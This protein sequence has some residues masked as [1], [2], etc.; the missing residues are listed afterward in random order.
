RMPMERVWAWMRS[1]DLSSRVFK[2]EAEI[3]AACAESWNR[4]TPERLKPSRD[5]MA[6]ARGVA[7]AREL[8]GMRMS[9][10]PKVRALT[11]LG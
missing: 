4:L 7:G 11:W 8:N 6:H 9:R 5:L 1:H 2:D 10:I 3:D